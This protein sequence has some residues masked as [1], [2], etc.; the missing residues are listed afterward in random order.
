MKIWNKWTWAKKS[1]EE[2]ISQYGYRERN[3]EYVTKLNNLGE[4]ITIGQIK[5]IFSTPGYG[6]HYLALPK[7]DECGKQ[8]DEQELVELGAA[9]EL[10]GTSVGDGYNRVNVCLPCVFKA[11]QM[12][13]SSENV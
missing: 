6:M 13:D 3:Q 7:C 12:L 8:D 1:R 5:E 9:I 11:F 4:S 2:W 10:G